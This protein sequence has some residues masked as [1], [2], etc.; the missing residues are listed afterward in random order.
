MMGSLRFLFAFFL[1]FLTYIIS[2]LFFGYGGILDYNSQIEY[3]QA[4][5]KNIE[6]LKEINQNLYKKILSFSSNPE[7][8][9]LYARE[10]GYYR[11]D[12]KVFRFEHTEP[13]KLFYR[14]GTLLKR[15][16]TKQ[17]DNFLFIIPGIIIFITVY[18]II[19]IFQKKRLNG[20][21]KR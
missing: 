14:V 17:N 20:S 19:T 8:I 12:E 3:S 6:E 2:T 18:F 9:R 7:T 13:L 10:L 16:N 11:A 1:G 15:N 5:D 21:K 4:L